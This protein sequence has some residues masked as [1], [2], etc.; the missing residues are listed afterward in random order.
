MTLSKIFTA[1]ALFAIGSGAQAALTVQTSNFMSGYTNYNGF[2]GLGSTF[3]Y[4]ANT[5]HTEGGIT[6][7]YV[8][9]AS[10]WS[11]SQAAEGSYSWYAGSGGTGYT[12]VTFG[13]V[14]NAVEFQAGSGWYYGAS[15]LQYEVL[16]GGTLIGTGQVGGLSTYTGFGFYGFSGA[17]FDELRLQAQARGATAF[18]PS[19][20]EAVALDA[21]NFGGTVGGVPEPANWA[22]LIAGFGLTGAAMRRRRAALAA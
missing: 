14:I 16:L 22:M 8:G 19:A 11:Y 20:Y 12:K 7:E 6:V 15:D 21:I 10:I 9:T 5:P 4:P 2:E 13:G 17:N 18:N 1:V 3:T